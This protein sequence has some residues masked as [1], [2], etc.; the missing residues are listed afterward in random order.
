[1]LNAKLWN[2]LNSILLI[3]ALRVLFFQKIACFRVCILQLMIIQL[4]NLLIVSINDSLQLIWRTVSALLLSGGFSWLCSFSGPIS[5]K[6]Y[7]VLPCGG[8][9][10]RLSILCVYLTSI[11]G[12]NLSSMLPSAGGQWHCVERNALISSSSHGSG[13]SYWAG[14]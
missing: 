13:L 8:I 10:V 1:M 4:I 11:R 14:L 6:M 3:T 2:F 12:L 7:A 5:Q 9:G